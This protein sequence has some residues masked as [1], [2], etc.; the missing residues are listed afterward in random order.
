MMRGTKRIRLPNATIGTNISCS[1]INNTTGHNIGNGIRR[2][3]SVVV[4][5][6]LVSSCRTKAAAVAKTEVR[7]PWCN[8]YGLSTTGIRL[9]SSSERDINIGPVTTKL[10]ELIGEGAVQ[11]DPHQSR[12]AKELDRLYYDLMNTDPSLS[13]TNN[14][15]KQSNSPSSSSSSS[16]GHNPIGGFFSQFFSRGTNGDDASEVNNAKIKGIY[17]YGGVGCGKVS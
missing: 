6:N 2:Y 9:L 11:E 7:V 14:D 3:E 16:S 10:R 17:T 8:S 12:A 1:L 5:K 4:N 15:N 13:T